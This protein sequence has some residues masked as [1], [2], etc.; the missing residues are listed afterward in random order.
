MRRLTVN[1]LVLVALG[2][3]AA[4]RAPPAA[5]QTGPADLAKDAAEVGIVFLGDAGN[6]DDM[7]YA[8]GRAMAAWCA[9]HRCD[10]VA[11]LGDNFYPTG[12]RS[13]HDRQWQNKFELPYADVRV[14]FRPILGNHDYYGHQR[15]ELVYRSERWWMP[16]RFYHYELGA[17]IA[18]MVGI[19]TQRFSRT[20]AGRLSAVLATPNRGWT[21]VYGHFP[22][23]SYGAHGGPDKL[24]ATLEP[25][26]TGHARFYLCGHDHD[27][28][29]I[30]APDGVTY[31]VSGGGGAET[32]GVEGGP[33]AVFTREGRGFGYL[34]LTAT[35]ATL[36]M[37]DENGVV[38]F[39][40]VYP[41]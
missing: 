26:L 39:E 12:V 24:R 5:A 27:Q 32:R 40:K 1:S 31:V 33:G 3:L 38:L 36:R 8:V 21:V 20:Q 17:G 29:V 28:Q 16:A 15:A 37:L 19:D 2:A 10:V 30:E 9:T 4:L 34:S 7:Q 18:T 25:M 22:V 6:G 14:P 23:Y 11:Y 35:T 41:R 13:S